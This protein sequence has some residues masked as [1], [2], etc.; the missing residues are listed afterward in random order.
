[1]EKIEYYHHSSKEGIEVPNNFIFPS[2]FLGL[3]LGK[4]GQ[5]KTTL[6]RFILRE[7]RLL[8]KKFD[9]VLVVSPSFIE[10]S[11]LFLPKAQVTDTVDFVWLDNWF[12]KYQDTKEYVNMLIILDD[13]VAGLKEESTNKDLLNLIF[14]RRHKLSNVSFHLF[15]LK[16]YG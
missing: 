12:K 5:G 13:V 10:F 3:I 16:G 14:N 15:I 2:H 1:M 6:L 7:K 8:F 11:D 4:P 9:V